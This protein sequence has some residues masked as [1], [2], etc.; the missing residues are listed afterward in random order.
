MNYVISEKVFFTSFDQDNTSNSGVGRLRAYCDIALLHSHDF[1]LNLA[2]QIRIC[3]F[4][5]HHDP[6]SKI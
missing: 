3:S 2:S 5:V 4:I 6:I 1:I